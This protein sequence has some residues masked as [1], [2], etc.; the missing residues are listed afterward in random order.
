MV[1]M[2]LQCING[3]QSL[4]IRQGHLESKCKQRSIRPHPGSPLYSQVEEM[5]KTSEGGWAGAASKGGE[6]LR[7]T[8][9]CLNRET[10]VHRREA[11]Y[12]VC[13]WQ[14]KWAGQ[15]DWITGLGIWKVLF[16][17][18]WRIPPSSGIECGKSPLQ[19][20]RLVE[21]QFGEAQQWEGVG[22][23]R[24]VRNCYGGDDWNEI[25]EWWRVDSTIFRG[26]N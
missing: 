11:K 17:Q 1:I 3:I 16:W 7:S 13:C 8:D 23:S 21:M 9:A 18:P 25:M 20:A 10:T 5:R 6:E 26:Q 4:E 15:L 12:V 22:M 24:L 14:V 2:S 19:R